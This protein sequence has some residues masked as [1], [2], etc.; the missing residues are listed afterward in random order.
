MQ[1]FS[2]T[3]L[4]EVEYNQLKY[5]GCIHLSKLCV[6]GE[7]GSTTCARARSPGRAWRGEILAVF[8]FRYLA[9]KSAEIWNPNRFPN[10][11]ELI[12]T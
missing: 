3:L 9:F 4:V 12:T 7:K 1:S 8:V 2:P 10:F 11:S 5:G 6:W